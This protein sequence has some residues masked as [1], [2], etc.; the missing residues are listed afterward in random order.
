M[1]ASWCMESRQAEQ[2]AHTIAAAQAAAL[3]MGSRLCGRQPGANCTA[4]VNVV[5]SWSWKAELTLAATPQS[6]GALS[7]CSEL[8]RSCTCKQ[9]H[10][11]LCLLFCQLQAAMSMLRYAAPRWLLL[12]VCGLCRWRSTW[13]HAAD[14]RAAKC[15]PQHRQRQHTGNPSICLCRFNIP[16][17]NGVFALCLD[18]WK[19]SK[20][21]GASMSGMSAHLVGE[22]PLPG[23]RLL[24]HG[25]LGG[26]VDL[27]PLDGLGLLEQV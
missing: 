13:L 25:G 2:N 5:E 14:S 27:E 11:R 17:R 26:A 4:P 7:A 21:P 1:R 12:R 22:P 10:L 15:Q 8:R 3:A 9:L 24:G 16:S 20:Q 6:R 19:S 23:C 18:C